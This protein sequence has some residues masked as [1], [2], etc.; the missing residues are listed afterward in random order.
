MSYELATKQHEIFE[1]FSPTTIRVIKQRRM[2]WV[3][4]LDHTDSSG[5][6]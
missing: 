3:G 2:E 5:F 6:F 1:H 4:N